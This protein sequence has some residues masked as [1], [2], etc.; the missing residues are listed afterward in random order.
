[1]E[2]DVYPLHARMETEH[3]WFVARREIVTSLLGTLVAPDRGATVLDVG[4]GTGGTVGALA[5]HYRCYG[6]DGSPE[7]IALAIE[8]YPEGTFLV[9]QAPDDLPEVTGSADAVLLMDVLEHVEDD[10][11][12]L[13]ELVGGMRPGA[14]LLVTVPA[15]PS[16]WSSHDVSHG[17]YRRYEVPGLAALWGHLPVD[18]LLISYFNTR[19]LPLT[20]LV[21]WAAR[22]L[23]RGFGESGTDLRMP[24]GPLNRLL[25]RIFAGEQK[26]LRR[27]LRDGRTAYS[28]G[29]S[30]LAVLRVE[31]RGSTPGP[32]AE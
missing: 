11:R 1:M 8:R 17:H 25:T 21:R 27:A 22:R 10:E 9:G 28:R 14:V 31:E 6:V 5:P 12:L 30:L 29:V 15:D 13:R 32:P 26:A 24:P 16:L 19:L 20:R 3:W 2:A 23:G 4:C 18:P 7:A